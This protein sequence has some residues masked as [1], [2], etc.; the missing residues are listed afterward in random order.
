MDNE[1][2]IL[3]SWKHNAGNWIHLLAADGIESR[4]L[5]TNAA[6]IAAVLASKPQR[7][8]DV[9]CGEGWLLHQIA[10]HGITV[11]GVDAIPE[12]INHASASTP[13]DFRVA[14]Y[15]EIAAGKVRFDQ[16]FNCIVINFALIG[17]ESTEQLLAALPQL[18][19][20]NGTLLIQTLHPFSRK[21]AGDY[22]TG[23]KSGSWDGLGTAFTHAYQWYFRTLED[24]QLLL[25][26]TG[27][28]FSLREVL[29]PQS[30]AP[31]S[32][33]FACKK[34]A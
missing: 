29:H 28:I 5:A 24:W 12:L 25:D 32:V 34:K 20:P 31:L 14:T 8:L 3:D 15:E 22:T 7:V 6:I 18:L 27:W 21:A 1:T 9:G 33:I 2:A 19:E 4:K 30:G 26:Q 13:G 11:A 16:P 17:K 10:S 23:W